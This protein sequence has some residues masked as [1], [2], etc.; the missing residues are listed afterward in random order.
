MDG[1][2]EG[3]QKSPILFDLPISQ[4]YRASLSNTGSF[5]RAGSNL[6]PKSP[7]EPVEDQVESKLEGGAKAV[8]RLQDMVSGQLGEMSKPARPHLP[9][10]LVGDWLIRLLGVTGQVGILQGEPVRRTVAA[11]TL[12]PLRR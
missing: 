3:P 1:D 12:P 10:N 2:D 11:R 8:A 5:L 7:L 6:L 9:G 4:D